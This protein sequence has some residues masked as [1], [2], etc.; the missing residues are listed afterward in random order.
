ME[1]EIIQLLIIIVILVLIILIYYSS[2]KKNKLEY[3]NADESVG[4]FRRCFKQFPDCIG[5]A[6]KDWAWYGPQCPGYN[7]ANKIVWERRLCKPI[8]CSRKNYAYICPKAE[9]EEEEEES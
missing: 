2:K 1:E 4:N 5:K 8:D 3:F 7:W 6:G 9:E